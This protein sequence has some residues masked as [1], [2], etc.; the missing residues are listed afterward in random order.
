MRFCSAENHRRAPLWFWSQPYHA[1][2][3]FGPAPAMQPG[4]VPGDGEPP[5]PA[6]LLDLALLSGLTQGAAGYLVLV[7]PEQVIEGPRPKAIICSKT[8]NAG[9]SATVV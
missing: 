1:T 3:V 4:R 6:K 9:S 2:A 7:A 5:E 8:R